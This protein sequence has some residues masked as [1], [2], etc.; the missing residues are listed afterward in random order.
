M[1]SLIKDQDIRKKILDLLSRRE[2]SKYELVL[3]LERRVDSSD[4]LLKEIDKISDQNL[5]SDERFSESYIRSRYNSGFGPS[6]IKYDLVKR[7][8][9]ESIINDA[10]RDID[11]NWLEKL[12]K[13]NIKKYGNENPKNMQ[14]LSRRT[15]F[16]VQRGFDQEMI[17]KIIYL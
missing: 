3:K 12:K 2:H 9:A 4:K 13:E 10:F 11:L 16:F 15:K 8:V 7:R 14:E 6:R 5:Q 1:K 17:R